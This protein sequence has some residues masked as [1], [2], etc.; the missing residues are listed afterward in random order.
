M[1]LV[2]FDIDGTL[3]DSDEL[4]EVCFIKAVKDFWD[5][6]TFNTD[7]ESYGNYTDSFVLR[8][9][10][11]EHLGREPHREELNAFEDY[12]ASLLD[13]AVSEVPGLLRPIDGAADLLMELIADTDDIAVGI[14]TGALRK[15]AERKLS[16]FDFDIL[17]ANKVAFSCSS[18]AYT[19]EDI[20]LHTEEKMKYRYGSEPFDAKIYVGDGV[21]DAKASKALGYTFIG[22]GVG[23]RAEALKAEGAVRVFENYLPRADF[24][25]YIRTL[26]NVLV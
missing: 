24:V 20:I 17:G 12:F 16:A 25:Q 7:W 6:D 10:A 11:K 22:R 5:I 15:S 3:T 4:D 13:A 26:G 2:I 23:E 8:E 14:A 21:W 18:D 19:R 1:N 9:I